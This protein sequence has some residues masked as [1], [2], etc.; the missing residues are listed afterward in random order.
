[1]AELPLFPLNAVLFPGTPIYLH[2]FEP[3]YRAMIR[4]CLDQGQ[5]FGVV[6]IQAGAEA[7]GPLPRPHPVGCRARIERVEPLAGGRMHLAARGGERFRILDL[8]RDRPYLVAE[9]E[10]LPMAVEPGATLAR[11]AERLRPWAERYLTLLGQADAQSRLPE[12]LPAAPLELAWTI[13]WI[14]RLPT[15]RKQALLASPQASALMAELR[16]ILREELPLAQV[17]LSEAGPPMAGPFSL[18]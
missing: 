3:R 17:L 1:M 14:L 5:D 7:L 18:N 11:E 9:V 4:H 13:A 12:R 10:P 16:R 15:P 8:M 2:V 6:L